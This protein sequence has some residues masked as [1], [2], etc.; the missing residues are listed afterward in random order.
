[1]Y[2]FKQIKKMKT[3]YTFKTCLLNMTILFCLCA[4]GVNAQTWKANIPSWHSPL[5][6]ITIVPSG[7]SATYTF[8]P[9][10]NWTALE[11]DLATTQNLSAN[12]TVLLGLQSTSTSLYGKYIVVQ[13]IDVAGHT[14][15]INAAAVLSIAA[16]SP[17]S[18]TLQPAANQYSVDFSNISPTVDF[19]Q[20]KGFTF[21]IY[22]SVN[23]ED[24]P[25]NLVGNLTISNVT[26][27]GGTPGTTYQTNVLASQEWELETTM[28]KLLNT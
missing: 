7:T 10:N 11:F 1:M 14:S 22:N 8:N 15:T 4:N 25:N 13:I 9:Y 12:K 5:D 20:I 28:L 2:P 21:I 19:T 18:P 26:A 6:V 17:L 24:S 27:G 3:S 23:A 16:P